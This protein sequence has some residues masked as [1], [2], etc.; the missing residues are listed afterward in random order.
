MTWIFRQLFAIAVL[1]FTVAVIIPVWLARRRAIG[2][3][4][5]HTLT[6]VALQACGM[7][8]LAVGILLFSTSLRRFITEG[9]GTLAPWDPP[10]HLVVAGPYRHVRNPMISGVLL[11]LIGEA[12]LLLSWHHAAWA[13][14]FFMINAIYIPLLE[15]PFLA[16]RFGESYREYCRHVPRLLPRWSPWQPHA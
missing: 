2:L 1:P 3:A 12:L 9:R 10:R 15:E 5:G 6:Q 11:V 14:I 7:A 4:P 8:I 13:L 16:E